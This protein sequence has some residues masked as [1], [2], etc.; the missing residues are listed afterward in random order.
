METYTV[1]FEVQVRVRVRDVPGMNP[2]YAAEAAFNEVSLGELIDRSPINSSRPYRV[3]VVR[4]MGG[5]V[6]HAV[7]VP[8]ASL[9][10]HRFELDGE[11]SFTDLKTA[12]QDQPGQLAIVVNRGIITGLYTTD[13]NLKA[14]RILNEDV[15]NEFADEVMKG[16]ATLSN[17]EN[18]MTVNYDQ[19]FK[20][21]EHYVA[22]IS[23]ELA[24]RGFDVSTGSNSAESI[25]ILGNDEWWGELKQHL[26]RG[27]KQATEAELAKAEKEKSEVFMADMLKKINLNERLVEYQKAAE[28]E[29][30]VGLAEVRV[31]G[32]ANLQPLPDMRAPG[33]TWEMVSPTGRSPAG[34]R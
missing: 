12:K 7:V 29:S 8:V 28:R 1:E 30:R 27:P 17:I 15:I 11:G 26:P 23:T 13:P 5:G 25:E 9:E 31:S 24:R 19:K 18:R 33:M 4:W 3:D 2:Q 22:K 6:V 21:W 32:P 20:I 16:E 34:G 14:A 10:T